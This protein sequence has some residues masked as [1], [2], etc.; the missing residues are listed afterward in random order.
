MEY[1]IQIT[2]ENGNIFHYNI[3]RSSPSEQ[4]TLNDFI[5]EALQ[6]SEDKRKLPLKTQCPNGLEVYPA[7]K[8]KFENYGN[9]LLG[10]KLEAMMLTWQRN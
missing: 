5:L 8:M 1:K 3:T 10:D 2:D 9:P 6:I 7:I 4:K